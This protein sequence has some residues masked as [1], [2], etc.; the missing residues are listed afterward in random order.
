MCYARGMTASIEIVPYAGWQN[1]LRLANG[2]VELVVTLDVGPRVIRYAAR[3]GTNLLG[4]TAEQLGRSGE[5]GWMARGGHRLWTAPEDERRTYAPDNRPVAHAPIAAHA[6]ALAKSVA[7]SVTGSIA[8]SVAKSVAGSV[9]VRFT[10]PPDTAYGVQKELEIA[11]GPSGTEVVLLHRISNVGRTPVE[12]APWA[13]T[14]M[15]PGGTAIIPLPAKRPHPGSTPTRTASDYWPTQTI[16]LWSYLDLR[17]PRLQLG[18]HFVTVRHDPAATTQFKIGLSHDA[19][20][21]AY[22]RAGDL[23][24]KTIENQP[25]QPYPDRGSNFEAYADANILE[26]ETL[27][28]LVT[29]APGQKT[30]H[31]ETWSCYDDVGPV[32]DEASILKNVVP[33]LAK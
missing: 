24:V 6:G 14:V 9:N 28:P 8:K 15:P 23:F 10:Q 33:R 21:L 5:P 26:M 20:W 3:G 13:L 30:E 27:G 22:W 25:G 31:V 12:L 1:N 11:L 7:K 2:D 19:G 18:T 29:L 17:D 32:T 4:E 16:A